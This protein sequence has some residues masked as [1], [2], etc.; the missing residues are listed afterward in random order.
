[1]V[2]AQPQ[3]GDASQAHH[4]VTQILQRAGAKDAP[5]GSATQDLLPLV[6]DELRR[7]A[8]GALAGERAGNTLQPTALVHEAYMRL[9]GGGDVS[10]NSRGHFFAAAAQ[11]MRRILVDRARARNAAK[12]GGPGKE[13]IALGDSALAVEPQDD[14]MLAIDELLEQLTAYD[15]LK[16]QI[17]MLRYFA[18]LSIEQ[19]AQALGLTEHKVK[20]E[21]AF[22]R[23]WMHEKLDKR[24]ITSEG[25]GSGGS[26]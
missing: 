15:K 9:V 6:Y 8:A 23:A 14:T 12:R 4:L 2:Q 18:G 22:T 16:A 10:W 5:A 17:V 1:M 25:G 19:T 24:S 3:P 20:S 11:A 21:W 26:G 7:M 13:R